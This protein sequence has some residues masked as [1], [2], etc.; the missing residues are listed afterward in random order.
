[1]RQVI[2][3]ENG[4]SQ[5]KLKDLTPTPNLMHHSTQTRTDIKLRFK[6]QARHHD[7]G[8]ENQWET[9]PR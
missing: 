3:H 5:L 4:H 9:V 7:P 6:G 1:M 8:D 2:G